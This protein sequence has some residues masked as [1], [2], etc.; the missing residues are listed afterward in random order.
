MRHRRQAG[1]L[2]APAP[3]PRKFAEGGKQADRN[4]GVPARRRQAK[5]VRWLAN[6]GC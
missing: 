1:R 3:A 6:G 2:K 5:L 4:L